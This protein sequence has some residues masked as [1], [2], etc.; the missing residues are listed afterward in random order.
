MSWYC[1]TVYHEDV[2]ATGLL[3]APTFGPTSISA[4]VIRRLS[5]PDTPLTYALPTCTAGRVVLSTVFHNV[6][7][8]H[9]VG[10]VRVAPDFCCN[11]AN[12]KLRGYSMQSMTWPSHGSS[13]LETD[14]LQGSPWCLGSFAGPG[15]AAG[16]P[17]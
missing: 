7:F 2:E 15:L 16:P 11:D 4:D 5:P 10:R 14:Q 13:V 12:L 9:N 17:A 3:G 8:V 6:G 1:S